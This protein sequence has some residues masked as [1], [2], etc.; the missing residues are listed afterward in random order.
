MILGVTGTRVGA[1]GFQLRVLAELLAQ[2]DHLHHGGCIGVDSQAH[3]LAHGL[4]LG[5]T[6]HWAR[7]RLANRTLNMEGCEERPP[8]P[9]LVRDRNIVQECQRLIVVP[10][11]D[12]EVLRSGTW[13]TCRHARKIHRDHVVIWP[14]GRVETVAY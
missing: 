10:R 12:R 2:G 1:T 5:I 11:G 3:S 9:P 6:V 14:S 13:A 4:Y 8:L 7:S